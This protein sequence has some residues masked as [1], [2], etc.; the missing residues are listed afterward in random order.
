MSFV[1]FL[2]DRA[3]ALDVLGFSA[4]QIGFVDGDVNASA[5]RVEL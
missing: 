2:P 4:G 5:A 3:D 1:V